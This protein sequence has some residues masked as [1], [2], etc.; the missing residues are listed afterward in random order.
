MDW[1]GGDTNLAHSLTGVSAVNEEVGAKSKT[2][3][4]IYPDH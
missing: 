2:K 1:A 3:K 4:T